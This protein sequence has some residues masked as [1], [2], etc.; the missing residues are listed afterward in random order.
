M[1]QNVPQRRRGGAVGRVDALQ[2]PAYR[3]TLESAEV[4]LRH[5]PG[6]KR[7]AP[8]RAAPLL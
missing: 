8:H 2:R 6:A 4:R 1:I 3:F 5:S 7:G